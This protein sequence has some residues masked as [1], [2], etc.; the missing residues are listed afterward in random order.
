MRVYIQ[1]PSPSLLETTVLRF[2]FTCV[3][4]VSG[5]CLWACLLPAAV[6]C[7]LSEAQSPQSPPIQ[8]HISRVVLAFQSLVSYSN[9]ISHISSSPC[10]ISIHSFLSQPIS[11]KHYSSNSVPIYHPAHPPHPG[12]I[13]PAVSPSYSLLSG[14]TIPPSSPIPHSP[15][16]NYF[17]TQRPLL[18]QH[19]STRPQL[20]VAIMTTSQPLYL[21]SQ[22]HTLV[23]I[24]Q[25]FNSTATV[26]RLPWSTA[27]HPL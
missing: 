23:V 27:S 8:I 11:L 20:S 5:Q 10:T 15:Q 7:L 26:T 13:T 25:R 17:L 2:S 3:P 24:L 21:H 1:R 9:F 4:C 16:P 14:H 12:G 19:S 18:S 22:L 6:S